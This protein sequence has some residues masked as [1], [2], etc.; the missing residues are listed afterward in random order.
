MVPS[1]WVQFE[2]FKNSRGYVFQI[3]R[4]AIIYMKKLYSHVCESHLEINLKNIKLW[5]TC[6]VNFKPIQGQL[7]KCLSGFISQ[8]FSSRY[9]IDM[10][11]ITS[12]ALRG[13]Y[14]PFW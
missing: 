3:A 4:E 11:L 13:V 10:F 8:W 7:Q 12:C 5:C 6:I 2:V 14:K 9:V 1:G